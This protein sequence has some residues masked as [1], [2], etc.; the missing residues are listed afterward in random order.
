[1]RPVMFNLAV[2]LVCALAL[3]VAQEK[4]ASTDPVVGSW[5]G[6]YDGS[7]TGKLT[8][9]IVRDADKRLGG[10]IQVTADD[11][12]SYT[13]TFTS[14]VTDGNAVAIAYDLS[15][16][17]GQVVQAQLDG[18]IDG[19]TLKGTWQVFDGSNSVVA[20]GGFTSSKQ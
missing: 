14:I 6:T 17:G 4:G 7:G 10:P 16:D 15:L 19:T 2:A 13:A 12:A 3:P 20:S 9:S 18:A 11:G 1:M 8:M 5:A